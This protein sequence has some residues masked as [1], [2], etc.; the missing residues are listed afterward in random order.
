MHVAKNV[1]NITFGSCDFL[2][3]KNICVVTFLSNKVLNSSADQDS[4]P[5]D[6]YRLLSHIIAFV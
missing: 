4:T 2:P 6:E 3:E 5:Y 1:A